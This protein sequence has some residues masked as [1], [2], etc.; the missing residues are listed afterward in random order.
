MAG[1]FLDIIII[2]ETMRLDEISTVLQLSPDSGSR[3]FDQANA[4]GKTLF[5]ISI[6]E[7]PSELL[8]NAIADLVSRYE[9]IAKFKDAR[10]ENECQ[11]LANF[12]FFYDTASCSFR[13]TKDQI[14]QLEGVGMDAEFSVY[15]C[16]G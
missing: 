3:D 11:M 13:L 15:H 6:G 14:S 10:I 1:V 5:K 8:S 7:F 12:G 9:F 16:E 4:R 2:S